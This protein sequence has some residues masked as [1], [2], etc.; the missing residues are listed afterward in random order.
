[1]TAWAVA[2]AVGWVGVAWVIL[3]THRPATTPAS[4][5]DMC[6]AACDVRHR[7][8]TH[9]DTDMPSVLMLCDRCAGQR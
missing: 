4:V 3:A 5:C 8:I 6:R 9:D 2:V 7:R 1:V